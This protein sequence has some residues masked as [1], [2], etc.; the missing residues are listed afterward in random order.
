MKA[1]GRHAAPEPV[2]PERKWKTSRIVYLCMAVVYMLVVVGATAYSLTAY[3]A[4]LPRVELIQSER[5]R[6]PKECLLPGPD[7]MLINTVERQEGPWGQRYVVKQLSVFAYQ[8][9]PDG[10]MFVYEVVSNENPIVLSSTAD[11]L[12]D[13][14]EV[15]IEIKD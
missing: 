1:K 13:G 3:Q 5:G 15:V 2:K 6:V 10:D 7:G 12:Y 4:S 8:E 9:L 11:F 14:M